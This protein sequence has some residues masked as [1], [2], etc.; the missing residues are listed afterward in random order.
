MVSQVK[1]GPWHRKKFIRCPKCGAII[2]DKESFCRE[3]G[4]SIEKGKKYEHVTWP[5]S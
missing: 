1:K 4:E 2:D 3:C 5:T